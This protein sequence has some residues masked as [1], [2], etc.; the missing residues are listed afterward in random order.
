MTTDHHHHVEEAALN[1]YQFL[2]WRACAQ[3]VA[4]DELASGRLFDLVLR[5]RDQT[6]VTAPFVLGAAHARRKACL[7]KRCAAWGGYND[8]V[9]LIPRA[10]M[11]AALRAPAEDLV[12]R[13]RAFY[14]RL[15]NTETILKRTLEAHGVPV[16][17]V[18]PRALPLVDA[19]PPCQCLV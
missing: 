6:V 1:V 11:E 10:H 14:S 3:A 12:S 13:E 17:E 5:L 19:R 9:M 18:S 2:N 15:V 8:K 16:T 7:V 4:A